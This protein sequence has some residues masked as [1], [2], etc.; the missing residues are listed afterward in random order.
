[1]YKS[2]RAGD[3]AVE[4]V[5]KAARTAEIRNSDPIKDPTRPDNRI[6]SS[7][8]IHVKPKRS[9]EKDVLVTEEGTSKVS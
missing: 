5:N 6:V 9:H 4:G 2:S 8:D 3:K 1:M 7:K